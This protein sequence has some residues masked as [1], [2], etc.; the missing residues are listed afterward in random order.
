MWKDSITL[1]SPTI[2]FSSAIPI[3]E[4]VVRAT[5][6]KTYIATSTCSKE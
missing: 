5:A 2:A 4:F 3:S 1:P 6:S